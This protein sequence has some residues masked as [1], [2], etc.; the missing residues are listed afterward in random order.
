MCFELI[1]VGR[2]ITRYVRQFLST[3]FQQFLV[4]HYAK[5]GHLGSLSPKRFAIRPEGLVVIVSQV[6]HVSVIPDPDK[7]FEPRAQSNL[8]R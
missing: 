3:V 2:H 1:L 5:M 6:Y 8:R 4:Q 7:G